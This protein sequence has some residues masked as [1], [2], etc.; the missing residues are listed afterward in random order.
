MADKPRY[1]LGLLSAATNDPGACIMKVYPD[2]D[3]EYVA[4]GEERLSRK[5]YDYAF[6][7]LSVDYCMRH[8][9]IEDARQIDLV[10]SDWV[11]LP[12][13][14][15]SGPTYNIGEFDY[16]KHLFTIDKDKVYVVNHHHAHS[17]AVYYS[18]PFDDAAILIVDGN[19]S[20]L[21]T[22][23]FLKANGNKI[24]DIEKGYY[25]GVGACYTAVTTRIL[26]F[27][28]GGEGKTMGLAPYG[29]NHPPVLDL[30]GHYAGAATDYSS[31][32][33]RLPFSDVLNQVDPGNAIYPFRKE[34][35]SR[36][37]D[38]SPLDPYFSRA[39]YEVQAETERVIVELA[40]ELHRR[41]PSKNICLSGGVMLNCVTNSLV[42]K[43]TPFEEAFLFPACGDVGVP[44]GL[45]FAGYHEHPLFAGVPKKR[46]VLRNAYLGRSY[47]D[48]EI[49]ST[50][51]RYGVES[52]AT[53]PADIAALLADGKIVAWFQGGAELGPRA[54]GH[55]SILADSRGDQIKDQVNHKVKRREGFRPFAPAVLEEKCSEHFALDRPSPF[56][57]L[58]GEA[59]RPDQIPSVVH[60]D[61]TARIQTVTARDNPGFRELIEEFDKLTGIPVILNTS[62]NVAGEP[63]VE[64]P[65]D[66]LICVF[67]TEMDYLVL[68]DRVIDARMAGREAIRERM[69]ADRETEIQALRAE[70]LQKHF[71][72]YD[73][74]E[75]KAFIARHNEMSVWWTKHR[76]KYEL[77]KSVLAW[78]DDKCKVAIAGEARHVRFLRAYINQFR[79]LEVVG[80]AEFG[81]AADTAPDAYRVL[82]VDELAATGAD[83]FIVA[84]HDAQY[85]IQCELRQR[86]LG[87]KVYLIYDNNGRSL[88]FIYPEP[89][90]E[91]R[92]GR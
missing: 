19:G 35:R 51:D 39:A 52:R 66:A 40:K 47:S 14:E 29:E 15:I 12:R 3:Y 23:S 55:R 76:A 37:K 92:K 68:H 85:R 6:P 77:E 54:L 22:N 25:Y 84:S 64:T 4:I 26:N 56:M 38:E 71:P 1:I 69:M 81:N 28:S 79:R 58:V 30:K 78:L 62:F 87:D 67:G 70:V 83:V 18:S 20:A 53:G 33:R 43:H 75:L 41:F 60:V 91:T 46:K 24:E 82:G 73:E 88:E 44:V 27:G 61:N 65:R 17:C 11:R 8:F 9:G 13:W 49:A 5:K 86:G 74:A 10:V 50:L 31:F 63:I 34:Y 57:L 32:M 80:Y 59:H 45:C 90:T 42:L 89:P 16:L 36:R 48:G 7:V 2:G 21:E 72:G